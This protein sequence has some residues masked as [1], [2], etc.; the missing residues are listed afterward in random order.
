PEGRNTAPAIALA[1]LELVKRDADAV[2]LVVPADHI[3]KGQKDFDAAVS[4]AADLALQGFLVTFGIK[5]IRP[6]TGYGYI[7]PNKRITIGKAGRLKGH[8]VSRFVEKP[9]VA[10]AAQ[11]VR[12]RDYFWNSGMFVWRAVTILEEIRNHQPSLHDGIERIRGLMREGT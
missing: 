4:L 8:P 1:A 5:P 10:K 3:V 6:E 2:M 9:D 11:Y 7:K 12:A